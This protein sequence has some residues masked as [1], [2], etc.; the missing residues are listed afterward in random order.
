MLLWIFVYTHLSKHL[1]SVPIWCI[2]RSGILGFILLCFVFWGTTN[3]FFTAAAPLCESSN[4]SVS[5]PSICF[6]EDSHHLGYN[7][8]SHLFWFE[9][10][11]CCVIL[12]VPMNCSLPDSSVHGILARILESVAISCYMFWF[13]FP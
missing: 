6:F 11:L 9:C 3:Q 8:V 7:V 1:F 4:F 10:M 5:S 13:A 12:C 2:S